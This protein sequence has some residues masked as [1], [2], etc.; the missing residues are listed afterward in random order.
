MPATYII[1]RDGNRPSEQY[2]HDKLH[3]SLLAACLS[4]RAPI[5]EAQHIARI[6]SDSVAT[7]CQAKSEITSRDIR[8]V[9]TN[10]L[11]TFHPEASYLYSQ[12]QLII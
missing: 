3:N 7:W 12:H 2:N 11:A 9:A 6:V 1:K 8:R 4:V 10:H 5:G